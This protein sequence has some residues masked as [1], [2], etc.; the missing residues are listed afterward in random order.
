MA[1]RG[2]ES[3]AHGAAYEYGVGHV[4]EVFD[5]AY[6]VRDLR[7]AQNRDKG[8]FRRG[9]HTR[10]GLDLA[11][12]EQS[13]DGRHELGHAG[14]GGMRAVRRPERVV[15]AHV[16]Q[17]GQA[18]H[19]GEVV[20]LLAVIEA[21]VLEHHHLTVFEGKT[22]GQRVFACNRAAD[23]G[24][25]LAQQL[26]ETHGHGHHRKLAFEDTATARAAQVARD[27]DARVVLD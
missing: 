21:Q 23:D 26:D 15:Y 25:R 17:A 14:D 1:L 7:A 5:D 22:C 12:H 6:L 2:Q 24:D 16:A 13:R 3:E 19:E 8:V 10:Q 11:S 20:F 27:D 18:V 9:E 4:H